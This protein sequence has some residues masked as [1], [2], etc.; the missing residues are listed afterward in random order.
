MRN[1]GVFFLK[2]GEKSLKFGLKTDLNAKE[3]REPIRERRIWE[4]RECVT[5][6]ARCEGLAWHGGRGANV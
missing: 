1:W 3:E 4:V 6:C 5:K 2:N